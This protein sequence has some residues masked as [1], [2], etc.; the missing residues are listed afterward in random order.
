MG[1]RQSFLVALELGTHYSGLW[2]SEQAFVVE[3]KGVGNNY[4]A[5]LRYSLQNCPVLE[6]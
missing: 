4:N 5:G 1:A 6:S 3:E 2:C